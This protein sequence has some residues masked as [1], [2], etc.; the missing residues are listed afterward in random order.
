MKRRQFTQALL[1][2]AL[3]STLG[4][5]VGSA[6]HAAPAPWPSKPITMIIPFPPGGTLDTVGRLLARRLGEQLGQAVVVENRAGGAGSIGA[7]AV[8][9]APAD[10]H[11]LLFNASALT[12]T[13]MT[14]KTA[15]YDV[16]RD[17]S[18]VALVAKAPLAIAVNRSLPFDDLRGLI[19]YAKA[20]PGRLSFA[21]GSTA[22]AGH[23]A[24]E[25]L[26]RSAGLDLLIVPYKGSA[27][28]Y[29]D[30]IGGQLD[31]FIDPILGSASFAKAGQLKV[32][33]V[34]SRQRVPSQPDLPTVAETV[35]GYEF[36]SWYGLW[37]PANLPGE[38]AQHLNAE[39]NRALAS[40]EFRERLVPQGLMLTPGSI[41]DFAR[42]QAD[43]M[44]RSARIIREGGIRAE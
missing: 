33:A 17:F 41:V 12:T 8:A 2:G 11:T 16:G 3:G 37:G 18:P 34:T 10:G 27:P 15:T 25:L 38:I 29:Q 6:A 22:S 26:R 35:P 13:P 9:R 21:V 39:V 36:H 5:L 4:G 31:A 42:F 20:R 28:A 40:T 19:A 30:L 14:L 32:L 44:I 23:L 7:L 43:D 1:G 24:T